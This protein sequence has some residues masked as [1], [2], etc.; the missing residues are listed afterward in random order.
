MTFSI[1]KADLLNNLKTVSAA[2]CGK[3]SIQSLSH[4]LLVAKDGRLKLTCTDLTTTICSEVPCNVQD[5]GSVSIPVR[6]ISDAIARVADGEVKVRM[7]KGERVTFKA[8][9][10]EFRLQGLPAKDFPES[11]SHDQPE[12]SATIS[13]L[14]LRNGLRLV[15]YAATREETRKALR[16]VLLSFTSEGLIMLAT[17]GRRMSIFGP[18]E[19][20]RPGV[21]RD[22]ILPASVVSMLVRHVGTDGDAGISVAKNRFTVSIGDV[23][24]STLLVDETYPNWRQVVPTSEP[25]VISVDRS[26][27]LCAIER[28]S[29]LVAHQG[30]EETS[31]VLSF[32]DNQLVVEGRQEGTDWDAAR[33]VVPC[34]FG[35]GCV[36][37]RMNPKYLVE[38]L[39]AIDEDSVDLLLRSETG[40][41]MIK[42]GSYFSGLVM[43]LRV[44]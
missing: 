12:F 7:G 32:H 8:G 31:I 43:P 3:S 9:T 5:E 42:S 20:V 15:E 34:K 44:R 13:Q 14:T 41:M 28:V 40:P 16:G 38:P 22:I 4:V 18:I 36:N 19:S 17:D 35:E 29:V 30:G 2:A 25:T 24:I 6:L 11:F 26:Q 21:Q 37:L 39:K 27:L 33:D 1:S 23:V 10:A